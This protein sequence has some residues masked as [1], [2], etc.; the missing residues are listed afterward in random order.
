LF[1]KGFQVF[2][3]DMQVS[4]TFKPFAVFVSG[5]QRHPSAVGIASNGLN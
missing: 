4:P 2:S 5:G 3:G 1:G